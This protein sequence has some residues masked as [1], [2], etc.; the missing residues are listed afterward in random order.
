M[1]IRDR[2]M[3]QFQLPMTGSLD[4]PGGTLEGL[5]TSTVTVSIVTGP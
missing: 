5:Y 4:I 2:G 3:G 1:C